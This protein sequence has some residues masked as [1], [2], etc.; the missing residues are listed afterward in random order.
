MTR[1]EARRIAANIAKLPALLRE[2]VSPV[3]LKVKSAALADCAT[4]VPKTS[5]VGRII[6]RSC[7][8]GFVP[9]GTACVHINSG[10]VA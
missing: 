6:N 8:M 4:Q 1:D 10:G 3:Q 9:L 5:K 7:V 2:P